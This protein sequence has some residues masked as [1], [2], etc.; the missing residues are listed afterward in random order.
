MAEFTEFDHT[1]HH[2]KQR[3]S[4]CGYLSCPINCNNISHNHKYKCNSDNSNG[5]YGIELTFTNYNLINYAR[6]QII[7]KYNETYHELFYNWLI[8]I[9]LYNKNNNCGLIFSDITKDQWGFDKITIDLPSKKQLFIHS[10]DWVFEVGASP[11]TLIEFEQD[12]ELIQ[13][14]LFDTAFKVG[15]YPHYRIGC[16]HLHL[17]YQTHFGDNALLFRNFIVDLFIFTIL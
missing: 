11:Y 8:Q 2:Y 9:K 10:D 17:E 13:N 7:D 12:H 6:D 1:I 16:G 3:I 15:L 4:D 14:M 5:R